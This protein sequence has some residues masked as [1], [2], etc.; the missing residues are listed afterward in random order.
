MASPVAG[1]NSNSV[2]SILKK[3]YK[4]GGMT[5]TTFQNRPYWTLITKK[6]DSSTVEGSTFQFAM[7]TGDVQSRNTVFSAAQSQAW[8]LTGNVSG[9]GANS[10]TNSTAGA[11]NSGAINTTQFSVTRAYNYSYAVISTTLALQTCVANSF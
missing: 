3:W 4:D 10:L 5:I 8:G 1:N 11:P 9:A 2:A 6:K 7:R